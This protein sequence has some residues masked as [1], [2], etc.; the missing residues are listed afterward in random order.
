M[1]CEVCHLVELFSLM[2]EVICGVVNY[3]IKS[4][5][6]KKFPSQ[7][8]FGNGFPANLLPLPHVGMSRAR[9]SATVR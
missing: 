8:A 4:D 2:D 3:G 5:L 9:K 6:M 7:T 1:T